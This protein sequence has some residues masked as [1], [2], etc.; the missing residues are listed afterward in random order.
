MISY[1][2]LKQ[3]VRSNYKLLLIFAVVLTLYM[4]MIVGMYD[5]EV[6]KTM[7][8]LLGLLPEGMMDAFGFRMQDQT[9]TGFTASYMFG[10][11]LLVVPLIYTIVAGNRIMAGSMENGSMAYLI[12]TPN[13]RLKIAYTQAVFLAGSLAVLF[14]YV[15]AVGVAACE[16]MFPG[17]LRIGTYLDMCLGAYLLQ[18]AI[19]GMVYYESCTSDDLK[20]SLLFGTGIGFGFY[21]VHMLANM[22][23]DLE[24]LKYGTI[25]TL[26]DTDL[27][28]AVDRLGYIFMAILASI[29]IIFY[30]VGILVFRKRDLSI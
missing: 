17:Q 23:G 8:Q 10:F 16:L 21:L 6:S 18:F 14:V 30:A 3:S 2:L 24:V 20:H 22:G 27:I 5:P 9:L 29:G 19:S 4:V 1:P 26:F 25:F 13:S 12:G 7:E 15:A 28:L 11:L